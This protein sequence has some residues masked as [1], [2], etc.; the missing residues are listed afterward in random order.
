MSDDRSCADL[1]GPFAGT[2]GH[3]DAPYWQ[4]P[5][6]V[7]ERMLDLAGA[8]PG[9]VLID[10]GCGDGRIVV[11]AAKRGAR[12]IGVD[13]DAARIGEAQAAAQEAGVDG[14]TEFRCEDLFATRL[15]EASIVSLYLAG[16]VNRML[17]PRLKTEPKPGARIIGYCFPMHDWPP[18]VS[19]TF[20]HVAVNLW[21]VPER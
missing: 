1:R 3:L 12:A 6:P 19:E 15:D 18:D 14:L 4:T 9:D 10:L 11:A 5:M 2:S 20:E 13:I 16:H 7:I 17:A 8:G 21:T